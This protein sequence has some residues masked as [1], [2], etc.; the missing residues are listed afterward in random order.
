M[1]LSLDRWSILA[2]LRFALASVVVLTHLGFYA[3]VP[4][5]SAI[6]S[7]AFEAIA[8]FLLISGYSI[9]SSYTKSPDGF[10]A[11]RAE[12]IY[13]SYATALL[14]SIW[15]LGWPG[16]A[17][18]LAN[19]F[20]LNQLVTSE[21]WLGPAWSL[22]LEVWLYA[23]TPLLARLPARPL[24]LLTAA[25]F[26]AF[27]AYQALRPLLDAPYF[28]GIGYGANLILLSSFWLAG[29]I[30]SRLPRKDRTLLVISLGLLAC[31]GL[32]WAIQ[33]AYQFKNGRLGLFLAGDTPLF[34]WR[35]LV[36]AA[37]A[38]AFYA[39]VAGLL[40]KRR[41][42]LL[43]ILGDISYPLY[44]LHVPLFIIC[45]RYGITSPALLLAIVLAAAA[46]TAFVVEFPIR[47]LL[48]GNKP[49]AIAA[50]QPVAEPDAG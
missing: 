44:L 15:A 49:S 33:G 23:L 24:W 50:T 41:S 25:S 37:V 20:L 43:Y 14:V 40:G 11:R 47:H 8:G 6:G 30:L 32:A 16:L 10:Y 22:S 38:T 13:P 3:H 46:A 5:A 7:A 4:W 45:L 29:F 34:V 19:F 27:L 31:I 48:R 17:V 26:L 39:I 12:R 2:G 42:R 9:G 36:L 1:S 18:F 35:G 21:S 28:A